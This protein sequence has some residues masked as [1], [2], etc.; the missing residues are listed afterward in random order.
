MQS[1][2]VKFLV[3]IEGS[4]GS[5]KSTLIQALAAR[6]KQHNVSFLK[7]SFHDQPMV[8]AI[9]RNFEAHHS[10]TRE[11]LS[12]CLWASAAYTME[13]VAGSR[14]QLVVCD[15]YD[16]TGRL[17]DRFSG[18]PLTLTSTNAALLPQPDLYVY[19]DLSP[20]IALG[21]VLSRSGKV[22]FYETMDQYEVGRRNGEL[23]KAYQMGLIDPAEANNSFLEKKKNERAFAHELFPRIPNLLILDASRPA[24]ALVEDCW[25]Q[26]ATGLVSCTLRC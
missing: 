12:A 13:E 11:M 25:E 15:R 26:I 20:H 5:G 4:D 16:L 17:Y 22:S 24:P 21:R 8:K 1:N 19:L 18:I 23:H 3:A 6:A 7:R 10:I 2:T 9:I 14:A